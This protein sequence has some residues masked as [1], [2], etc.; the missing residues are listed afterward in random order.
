MPKKLDKPKKVIVA[1][2]GGVD[3]SVAAAILKNKGFDVHGVF[4]VMRDMN[5]I[6]QAKALADARQVAQKL[7]IPI[8]TIDIRN[9][10]KKEVVDYFISQYRKGNTPNPCVVCNPRIKFDTLIW[11]MKKYKA[12]RVATGHYAR[13]TKSKNSVYLLKKATDETK[14]QSYFLWSI[15]K[16][17]L[18]KIVFPLGA[19]TKQE[20]RNLAKEWHLPVAQKRESQDICFIDQSTPA[21][22]GKHL[23]SQ[24]GLIVDEEGKILGKHSGLFFYT[25]GQ[26]KRINVGGKGPYYVCGKDHRKNVLIVTNDRNYQSFFSKTMILGK[27]NWFKKMERG[28]K[29]KLRTRY[30]NPL[31]SGII[32]TDPQKK[33]VRVEVEFDQ[34]Q[35]MITRGQ[36]AVFYDSTGSVAGGGIII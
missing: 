14:D 27:T 24:P 5:D 4:F 2:S 35:R 34:P 26:R 9:K 13:I 16:E 28:K 32:R 30:R 21:F 1:M 22:L 25:L 10:F 23:L 19:M 20:V 29:V 6:R 12:D 18:K 31:V 8:D 33:G 36:S 15:K 11:L 7:E 17:Q 3:S